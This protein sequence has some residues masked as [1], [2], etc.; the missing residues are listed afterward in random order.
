MRRMWQ[1]LKLVFM[2]K[3][4]VVSLD[5]DLEEGLLGK[6]VITVDSNGKPSVN[7]VGLRFGQE[8]MVV[9]QIA[10]QVVGSHLERQMASRIQAP[11]MNSPVLFQRK[12]RNN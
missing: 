12:G 3:R 11:P 5:N 8:V 9:L 1:W 4:V 2:G 6:V 7:W 10:L